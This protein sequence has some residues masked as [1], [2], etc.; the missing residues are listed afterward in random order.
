MLKAEPAPSRGWRSAQ[1][2]LGI[3]FPPKPICFF[4]PFLSKEEGRSSGP[5]LS[6][7]PLA[8]VPGWGSWGAPQGW[9]LWPR[10]TESCSVGDPSTLHPG[11]GMGQGPT[12]GCLGWEQE[13]FWGSL[14][15]APFVRVQLSIPSPN[16][17]MGRGELGPPKL[18][19]LRKG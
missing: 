3:K 2:P 16:L 10:S 19:A 14:A 15:T 6:A 17:E 18:Q 7:F 5:C 1:E 12:H 11:M 4:S 13:A 9:S 8:S